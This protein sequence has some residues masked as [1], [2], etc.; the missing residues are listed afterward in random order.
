MENNIAQIQ[1]PIAM[2]TRKVS[3]YLV[4][5]YPFKHRLGTHCSQWPSL[6][7]SCTCAL[8]TYINIC[9]TKLVG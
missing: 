7:C 8:N 4:P 6:H 9:I 5:T 2:L 3:R 1:C